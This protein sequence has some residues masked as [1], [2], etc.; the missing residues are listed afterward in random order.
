[1]A[2]DPLSQPPP[3]PFIVTAELPGDV[4]A[5]SDGLRRA[6]F[7]PDRN[8][9]AAHVTLFHAFAPS[10]REELLRTL[11]SYA[12]YH[13]PPRARI[14]ALMDLGGGTALLVRSDAMQALRRRIADHFDTMLTAQDR[15]DKKLHITIQNKVDRAAA[16]ALQ[17]QLRGQLQPREFVFTG[18][19]LHLYRAPH[20]ETVKTWRFRGKEGG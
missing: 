8:K 2:P 20:W 7:P 6:H 16:R 10:L 13:S 18:F 14:D 11:G 4:L 1:M 9:L 3:A 5:W 15:G 12:A 19:G 17:A